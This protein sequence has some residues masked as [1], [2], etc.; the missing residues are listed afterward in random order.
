MTHF[1]K[2]AIILTFVCFVLSIHGSLTYHNQVFDSKFKTLLV[3]PTSQP[4][5]FPLIDLKS[6]SID[7]S[8]DVLSH[9]SLRL[10]YKIIHCNADW[11]KSELF[12]S[13]FMNGMRENDF[14]DG[15]YSEST[16]VQYIHYRLRL[17]NENIQL[18]LSGNY[19][20]VVY[21]KDH[22]ENTYLTACFM[23][24]EP[25][26]SIEANI[27]A[28]T[29]LG[30]KNKFQQLQFRIKPQ[31]FS[32]VMPEKELKVKVLKNFGLDGEVNAVKPSSNDGFSYDF[33]HVKA[34]VFHGGNEY[35]RFETTSS[36]FSGLNITKTRIENNAVYSDIQLDNQRN[37]NYQYDQDQNGNY[38][39]RT[40]DCLNDVNT[41]ADYFWVNFS[42]KP[43]PSLRNSRMF[44]RGNLTAG[45]KKEDCE[46]LFD[47]DSKQF[48]KTLL[49]K[50]GSYN[51]R[52]SVESNDG[53]QDLSEQAEGSFWQT[54]NVYQ[55]LVYH[56]KFGAYADQLVGFKE[57]KCAF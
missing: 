43:D 6:G 37:L 44:I 21:D 34:L 40:V 45:M 22:P 19:A 26:A 35:R 15:L 36:R 14:P 47:T 50:Q 29:D 55:I 3:H 4:L 9:Q 7:I 12:E 33:E 54:E 17:P 24:I 42:F 28:D 53:L 38:L 56:R 23:I 48:R 16:F 20:L 27:T 1:R 5:N 39:I 11:T 25:K 10:G 30:Y 31:G 32:M 13:E 57:I 2:F 51:Y 41:C 8:F 18:K 52:Y 49:L 46:M